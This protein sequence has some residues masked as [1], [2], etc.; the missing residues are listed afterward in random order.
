MFW[1]ISIQKNASFYAE[2]R[3]I[4]VD[5]LRTYKNPVK[6]AS[7]YRACTV[8]IYCILTYWCSQCRDA[9]KECETELTQKGEM[10]SR[11]QVKA[12]QIGKI[13]TNLEKYNHFLGPDHELVKALRSPTTNENNLGEKIEK[14]RAQ[15]AQ[16]GTKNKDEGPPHK[17]LNLQEIPPFRRNASNNAVGQLSE[18]KLPGDA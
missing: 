2:C 6:W 15:N 8:F 16:K 12:E 7:D 3:I 5:L 1:G 4:E 10:V 11:L 13:L 18:R 9:W 17:K 14:F